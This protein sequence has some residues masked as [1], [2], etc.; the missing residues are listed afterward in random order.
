MIETNIAVIHLHAGTEWTKPVFIPVIGG[1]GSW[2]SVLALSFVVPSPWQVIIFPSCSLLLPVE[3]QGCKW[4]RAFGCFP[5]CES[6][7]Q[8]H[9]WVL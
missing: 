3:L 5:S 7:T 4:G 1:A 9:C 8:L 6:G 2:L